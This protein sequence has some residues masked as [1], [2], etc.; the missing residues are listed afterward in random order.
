M[1][2]NIMTCLVATAITS[3]VMGQGKYL[4][5]D[6]EISFFSHTIVEDIKAE[7]SKVAAVVDAASGEVVII[8]KMTEFRFVKKLMQEHFNENYVESEKFP[9]GTFTGS[10]TNNAEVDYSTPGTYEVKVSGDMTIHGVKQSLTT[11][12]SVEVTH[13]G[14]TARTK[15]ILHPADFKIKI[16]RIMRNNIAESIEI[17]VVLTCD[18][19]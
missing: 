3:S 9:K 13:S 8:V 16:P 15:F 17:T 18:P 2:R 5:N 1:R 7:N 19:I 14:I 11:D 6:G 12:G 10:I 4:T